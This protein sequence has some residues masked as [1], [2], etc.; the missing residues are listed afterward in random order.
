M[1]QRPILGTIEARMGSSRLP[2]KTLMEVSPGL[3]LLELVI[4]RFRRCRQ[5]D[6]VVVATTTS[7]KDDAIANYCMQSGIKVHRGSEDDVLDRVVAAAS[8]F[9]PD[10]I[11]QMGADS[12]YLDFE[13]I[14]RLV[15]LYK[16]NVGRYDYVC[17]DLQPGFPIGI[18]GHVVKFSALKKI[19]AGRD[20]TP[21][22]REDV[23][24]YLWN[25]SDAFRLLNLRPNDT[26]K[27][28]YL[29]LTID[30]PEDFRLLQNVL[31][32]LDRADF[33]FSDILALKERAP[34]IFQVVE[35]LVQLS[36]PNEAD[37]HFE[38]I[39]WKDS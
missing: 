1:K 30:Y 7:S 26:Y 27:H 2:G 12:A 28:P 39:E 4:K 29:R 16:R 37:I 20:V 5:V 21:K 38:S 3:H 31:S 23:V 18:Y 14:D 24:R 36:R 17:N 32:R 15:G 13:L 33:Q 25:H 19:S 10:A 11:V 6:E 8:A 35:K 22:E 9:E 34:E